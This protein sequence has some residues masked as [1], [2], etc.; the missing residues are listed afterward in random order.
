MGMV[1]PPT[2][3]ATTTDDN[4]TPTQ[5]E[6][7]PQLA[8]IPIPVAAKGIAT[9]AY[10]RILLNRIKESTLK[11]YDTNE[12]PPIFIYDGLMLPGSLANL[13]GEV[14][15]ILEPPFQN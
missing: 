13:L 6:A 11:P 5:T 8:N 3:E 14:H 2:T 12:F 1:P 7:R 15:E 10:D 9:G 4:N